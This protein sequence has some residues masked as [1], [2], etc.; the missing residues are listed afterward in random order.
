[1]LDF[2]NLTRCVRFHPALSQLPESGLAGYLVGGF[3]R[4][5][6]LDR[7]LGD[8]DLVLEGDYETGS[9]ILAETLGRE[10]Y[11][12]GDRFRT[13][14]FALPYGTVDVAPMQGG[15]RED[16]L[17]RR[18]FSINAI[19]LDLNYI[20]TE[21]AAANL[22]DP[23]KGLEDLAAKRVVSISEK[24]LLDDPLR[25]LRAF[26]FMVQLGFK[27]EDTTHKL[28]EIHAEKLTQSASERTREE[29]ML[30]LRCDGAAKGLK[31]MDA[32][33]VLTV[34]FPEIERMRGFAQNEYH[35]L[36]VL[37]HSLESV[38]EL[39]HI[40][41]TGEGLAD[42]V[43]ERVLNEMREIVSPPATRAALTKLALL[44]HDIGKPQTAQK[45]EDGRLSFY[46]HQSVGR[47][48]ASGA[49][50]RLRLSNQERELLELLIEEHLRIGF[51]CNDLPVSNKL[52]YRYCR[53]LGDATAMSCLHA[54]ADARATRGEAV[55]EQFLADHEEV[56]NAILWHLYVGKD[57]AEPVALL[58]GKQIME[59]TSL[60]EGPRVGELKE[61]LLEAQVEGEVRTRQDAERFILEQ[62]GQDQR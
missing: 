21:L 59:L 31:A 27:I 6:L 38:R 19:A 49:F 29:L 9:A 22:M 55:T 58:T 12:L 10:S 13:D 4:D 2:A 53:K 11:R 26:R 34:L 60:P 30:M 48:I 45:Q 20:G 37:E 62:A 23:A 56:A 52:I 41:A 1:M 28:L 5:A 40:L 54:L 35:H 15:S 25:L 61:A 24:N 17:L 46:G 39:E 7:N 3:I 50:E 57:V 36:P 14:R 33:G 44:F 32:A 16:D 47:D 42:D 43:R 51:Y 8:V 18:D